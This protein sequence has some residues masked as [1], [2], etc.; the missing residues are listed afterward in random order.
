MMVIS[1]FLNYDRLM[2]KADWWKSVF[3]QK[4]LD[5][6]SGELTLER[7]SQEVDFIIKS[8]SLKLEDE[9]LDLACGQGRH[10]IEL[11]KRGFRKITGLDYSQLL[12]QKAKKDANKGGMSINFIRGDMHHLPFENKFDVVIMMFTAF[13]YFDD[14]E[15]QQVLE[16]VSKALKKGGKFL[17]DVSNI[18]RIISRQTEQGERLANSD[19]YRFKQNYE[20][21]GMMIDEV[22]EFDLETQIYQTHR[23]W[24]Q[25]G[26]KKEY[27]FSLKHYTPKQLNL[28]LK[29]AGLKFIKLWGDYDEQEQTETS[30]KTIILA[31]KS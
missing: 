24:K 20:V 19:T 31:Q 26:V 9:I 2:S 14:L 12:L 15:N 4:Y 18:Q 1:N 29:K 25:D 7:T 11:A 21:S 6:Y 30:R 28:M 3:D 13:G 8:M 27:D 10:S 23:Q 5:I 17:L 16:Q 22:S